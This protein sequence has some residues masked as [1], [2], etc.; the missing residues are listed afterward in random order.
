M[1]DPVTSS[2]SA[3]SR[4]PPSDPLGTPLP[5]APEAPRSARR[6]GSPYPKAGLLARGVGRSADLI[7]SLAFSALFHEV[8]VLAGLLYLLVADALWH[9]QSI[10]KKI[11]GTRAVHVPDRT[12]AGLKESMLRNLPFALAFLFYSVPLIGWLLFFVVGLPMIGFEG[13]MVYGDALGIRI[14]DIFAD[15]QVID[16][17]VVAGQPA[18]VLASR[19]FTPM[20]RETV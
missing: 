11:A 20:P 14:G 7:V 19:E 17:K 18:R 10:G 15:T 1:V 5:H 4:M 8:G 13:Y 6:Q 2:G 9:G 3:Q 16:G 12:P